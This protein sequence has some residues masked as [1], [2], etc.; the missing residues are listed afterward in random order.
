MNPE[1]TIAERSGGLFVEGRRIV[2]QQKCKLRHYQQLGGLDQISGG[3]DDGKERGCREITMRQCRS[4]VSENL[5]H[6]R[7]AIYDERFPP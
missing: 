3:L 7:M 4:S 5:R 1:G 6:C 2:L